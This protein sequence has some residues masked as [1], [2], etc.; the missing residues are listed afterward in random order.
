VVKVGFIGSLESAVQY[1]EALEE[2]VEEGRLQPKAFIPAEDL[3]VGKILLGCADEGFEAVVVLDDGIE[4]KEEMFSGIRYYHEKRAIEHDMRVIFVASEER[5]SSD[6]DVCALAFEGVYDLVLPFRGDDPVEGAVELIW[7][8]AKASNVKY[9]VGR[10]VK[11]FDP[12]KYEARHSIGA[13]GGEGRP[14]GEQPAKEPRPHPAKAEPGPAAREEKEAPRK[15]QPSR[16]GGEGGSPRPQGKKE[17]GTPDQRA[18]SYEPAARREEAPERAE[19]RSFLTANHRVIGVTSLSYRGGSTTLALHIA[20]TIAQALSKYSPARSEQPAVALVTS[21]KTFKA[22]KEMYRAKAEVMDGGRFVRFPAF[23]VYVGYHVGVPNNG[24]TYTILD[25]GWIPQGKSSRSP[26]HDEME[27]ILSYKCNLPVMAVPMGTAEDVIAFVD[28]TKTR[29]ES[30]LKRKAYVLWGA[31]EEVAAQ[32]KASM[33]RHCPTTY[34]EDMGW[35]AMPEWVSGEIDPKMMDLLED[36]LDSEC[37][38]EYRR[39]MKKKER[40]AVAEGGQMP[41]A[42]EEGQSPREDEGRAPQ[43]EKRKFGLPSLFGKGR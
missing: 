36:V 38:R 11:P 19:Q 7:K 35:I 22:M 1:I 4:D 31:T 20:T 5:L 8:P 43:E 6:E 39:A 17:E 42:E 9:V 29:E 16:S 41:P 15:Q 23:D 21:E 37:V 33:L 18:S 2:A 40:A 10:D 26:V 13:R 12:V 14:S 28:L 25:L 32:A 30:E 24:Y 3:E 34:I 27:D